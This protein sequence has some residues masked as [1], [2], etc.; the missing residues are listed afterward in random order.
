MCISICLQESCSTPATT[1]STLDASGCDADANAIC[2]QLTTQLQQL[3]A[4]YKQTRQQLS[5]VGQQLSQARQQ[6]N[7]TKQQ[8]QGPPPH[9]QHNRLAQVGENAIQSSA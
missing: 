2:E 1:S 3:V 7:A 6:L 5:A 8:L 4:D 9:G